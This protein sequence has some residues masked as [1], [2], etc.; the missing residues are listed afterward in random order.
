LCFIDI[1]G[2][3]KADILISQDNVFV[4]YESVGKRGFVSESCT[5]PVA[6]DKEKGL[7]IL[8][9]DPTESI[10][11]ADFSSDSIVDIVCI[12]NRDICYWPNIGYSRFGTKVVI[13]YVL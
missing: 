1:T 8:F 10:Y 6:L 12:R 7:Y 9:S 5:I 4:W 3:G 2:N 13:D 11:L